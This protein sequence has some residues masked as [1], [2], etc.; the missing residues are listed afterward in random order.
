[1]RL[2]SDGNFFRGSPTARVAIFILLNNS[3]LIISD[4]FFKFSN[5]SFLRFRLVMTVTVSDQFF[6]MIS[7]LL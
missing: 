5:V 3:H 1:M 6:N 4:D 2:I 7:S